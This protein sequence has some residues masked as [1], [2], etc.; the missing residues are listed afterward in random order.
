MHDL[1]ARRWLAS[2]YCARRRDA[3]HETRLFDADYYREPRLD[4]HFM[5]R[6]PYAAL[7]ASDF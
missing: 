7:P 2:F 6:C 5:P 4:L 3:R 1:A